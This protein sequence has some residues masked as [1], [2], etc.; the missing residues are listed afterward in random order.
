M[1]PLFLK[2]ATIATNHHLFTK[3]IVRLFLNTKPY[4]SFFQVQF[5]CFIPICQCRQE[6]TFALIVMMKSAW[7]VFLTNV[8]LSSQNAILDITNITHDVQVSVLHVFTEVHEKDCQETLQSMILPSS[9]ESK[10]HFLLTFLSHT[11]TT[12]AAGNSTNSSASLICCQLKSSNPRHLRLIP[13]L[14]QRRYGLW[15][16]EP[17][18]R[19]QERV[20]NCVSRL[21]IYKTLHLPNCL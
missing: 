12:S 3:I 16:P 6:P 4:K 8:N 13:F 19:E 14:N 5:K 11:H 10:L 21:K 9:N 15:K 20:V 7:F 1:I 17:Y 2:H 18:T